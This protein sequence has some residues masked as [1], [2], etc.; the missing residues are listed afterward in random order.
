MPMILIFAN[1]ISGRGRGRKIAARLEQYLTHRGYAVSVF[2]QHP[3]QISRTDLPADVTA[4]IVIGGDGTLRAVAGIFLNPPSVSPTPPFLIVPFGTANLMGKHLGI[5]W[6]DAAL[7]SEVV[8]ALKT[9]RVIHLDVARANGEL[10]LLIAGIGLDAQVVHELTQRRRGS[11]THM[12][13]ALPLLRT[14]AAYAYPPLSVIVDDRIVFDSQ[15]AIVFI[16][17]VPE[18]GTGF[19]MLPNA[20]PTDGLLDVCVLPCRSRSELIGHAMRAVVGE[21]LSGEGVIY[22][23]GRRILIDSQT[24]VPVQVDGESAG[25]TP[26]AID[27]LTEQLGFI[28]PAN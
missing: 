25:H 15:P 17:N 16:G 26:L 18:Y 9:G 4:A 7:E 3:N 8:S 11:I 12:S 21:H 5:S 6:S 27:L 28:V 13:Y 22:A 10:M 20:L 14:L 19:S 1:P 2:L 24:P 23:R